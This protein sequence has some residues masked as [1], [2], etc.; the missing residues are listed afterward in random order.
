MVAGRLIIC[1][2]STTESGEFPFAKE[3]AEDGIHEGRMRADVLRLQ[4]AVGDLVC[5]IVS[6]EVTRP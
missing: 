5:W 3:H 6:M 1:A 4:A 2:I